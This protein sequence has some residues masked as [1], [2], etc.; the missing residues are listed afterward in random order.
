MGLGLC[1]VTATGTTLWLCK[2]RRRGLGGERLIAAWTA[3][4]W[5]V[6]LVLVELVW[7]TAALPAAPAVPLFWGALLALLAVAIARPEWAEAAR[8]RIGTMAAI[9][10]TAIG[11]AIIAAPTAIDGV[12]ALLAAAVL[13]AYRPRALSA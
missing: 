4:I 10:A 8:L 2:R 7:A 1:V 13:A 5:G 11:H 3:T 12:A 6:P 9:L